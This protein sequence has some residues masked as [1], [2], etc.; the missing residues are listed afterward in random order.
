MGSDGLVE[1]DIEDFEERFEELE[2]SRRDCLLSRVD[3]PG[4]SPLACMPPAA[5][6]AAAAAACFLFSSASFR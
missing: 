6:A 4:P 2:V 1:R 5:M 3:G